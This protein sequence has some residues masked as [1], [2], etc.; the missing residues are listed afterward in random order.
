MNK[1][2]NSSSAKKINLEEIYNINDQ[3]ETNEKQ[4]NKLNIK[5]SRIV[6]KIYIDL[7][8]N[9][10]LECLNKKKEM[11]KNNLINDYKLLKRPS[12]ITSSNKL[13]EINN[14]KS[15]NKSFYGL[16]NNQYNKQD[17]ERNDN[18]NNEQYENDSNIKYITCLNCNNIIKIEDV[19]FHTDTCLTIINNPDKSDISTDNKLKKLYNH[20]VK[21]NQ[22]SNNPKSDA[23]YIINLIQTVNDSMEISSISSSSL[24]S[25]KK[26]IINLECLSFNYVGSTAIMILIERLK[27]LIYEKINSM[28]RELNEKVVNNKSFN[29]GM[30]DM[31][32]KSNEKMRINVTTIKNTNDK[33]VNAD[34]KIN[35]NQLLSNKSSKK[36]KFIYNEKINEKDKIKDN[37]K[38]FIPNIINRYSI[39]S[40]STLNLDYNLEKEEEKVKDPILF[41]DNNKSNEVGFNYVA[42]D[43]EEKKT[44]K[45]N[46]YNHQILS[47]VKSDVGS[48]YYNDDISDC[49]SMTSMQSVINNKDIKQQI[50]DMIQNNFEEKSKN[51]IKASINEIVIEENKKEDP[52]KIYQDFVKTSLKIKFE[53]LHNSHK[54]WEIPE[55]VLFKECLKNNIPKN[56]WNVF[57]FNELQQP[58][59][60]SSY[61]KL[62]KNRKMQKN[63][64]INLEIIKEE[65][66][67]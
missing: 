27:V 29:S 36:I 9:Q 62:P 11:Y 4:S 53:K 64:G 17:K 33:A 1:F 61:F 21:I 47:E 15:K 48:K 46:K 10:D 34:L 20:L 23:S 35:E 5:N 57:I 58:Q 26:L 22:N 12:C 60:Y 8:S 65:N 24:C 2:T 56:Q 32:N 55:K 30:S 50:E 37:I 6:N 7:N 43:E 51:D 66:L 31:T 38:E 16:I 3:Y 67:I 25:L 42:D 18:F 13:I 19:D 14:E 41:I 40:N 28:K 59:K 52:K 63:V 44:V 39:N 54:G 45:G 49:T